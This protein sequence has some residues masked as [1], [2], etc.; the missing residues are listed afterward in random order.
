MYKE[1]IVTYKK[2]IQLNPKSAVLYGNLSQ[3]KI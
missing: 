2:A 1:S 3:A